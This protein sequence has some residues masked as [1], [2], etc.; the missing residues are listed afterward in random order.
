MRAR[1]ARVGG[2]HPAVEGD[3]GLPRA[4]R[5]GSIARGAAVPAAALIGE[6]PRRDVG[7]QLAVGG[8]RPQ[9]AA[10][11]RVVE[12]GAGPVIGQQ[13]EV[14]DER[15][16]VQAERQQQQQHEARGELHEGCGAH[17]GARDCETAGA[18]LA[19]RRAEARGAALG[20]AHARARGRGVGREGE[21]RGAR[22]SGARLGGGRAAAAS[23]GARGS[24]G[25]RA[26]G[27]R[28][29]AART[30]RRGR[31]A[32]RAPRRAGSRWTRGRRSPSSRAPSTWSTPRS[33]RVVN[34][35][36]QRWRRSVERCGRG[37]AARGATRGRHRLRRRSRR[38]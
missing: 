10:E 36:L 9:P 27:L 1:D 7:A 11:V 20:R 35:E 17:D 37:F 33:L 14:D 12:G 34:G 31:A 13:T 26:R 24:C 19:R 15:A 18:G 32:P 2:E 25:H 28:A 5:R 38:G 30:A 4:Q 21:G 22:G 29:T 16:H 23:S 8:G 3:D 6:L